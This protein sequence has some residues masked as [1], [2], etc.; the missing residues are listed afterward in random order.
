MCQPS[1]TR[2]AGGGTVALPR[3]EVLQRLFASFLGGREQLLEL[4]LELVVGA[5]ELVDFRVML[6]LVSYASALRGVL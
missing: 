6:R 1:T 2:E 5:L 3:D 4:R